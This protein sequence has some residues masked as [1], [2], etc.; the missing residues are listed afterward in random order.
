MLERKVV[1]TRYSAL[2]RELDKPG[3]KTRAQVRKIKEGL[4]NFKAG[5]Y[6]QDYDN[7]HGEGPS[8]ANRNIGIQTGTYHEHH[9]EC[10]LLVLYI[11]TLKQEPVLSAVSLVVVLVYE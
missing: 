2:Q 1:N 7:I 5:L 8:T 10:F 11:S 9:L 6:R 3:V 4:S